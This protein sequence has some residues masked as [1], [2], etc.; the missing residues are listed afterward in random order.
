MP[1][2]PPPGDTPVD[3][4]KW[5]PPAG[6]AALDA[7][8]PQESPWAALWHGA[9][10]GVTD[11][12]H[13]LKQI[14]AHA[15]GRGPQADVAERQR[16]EAYQAS[17]GVRQHPVLSGAGRFAGNVV[18]GAPLALIPGGEG[19]WLGRAG[20]GAVSGA[21]GGASQPATGRDQNFAA[22]KLWQAA[23]GAG[24]GAG[25]SAAGSAIGGAV[26]P[27]LTPDATKLVEKGVTLTAGQMAPPYSVVRD[28][29][30][31]ATSYP[32][33]GKF[34]QDK[35]ARSIDSFNLATINQALEPIGAALPK[36]I[37]PAAGHDAIKAMSDAIGA[38]Y[39]SALGR[40]KS[41]D[42]ADPD[43]VNAFKAIELDARKRPAV[44][45]NVRGVMN[46]LIVNKL[47]RQRPMSGDELQKWTS[48]LGRQSRALGR[49]QDFFQ[50][51]E[52]RFLGD[53]RDALLDAVIRQHP[54][55]GADL[56]KA[57]E[58]WAMAVRIEDAAS[59]RVG[60]GGRFTPMDLLASTKSH[61]GGVR[62]REFARG[63]SLL[64]KWAE[65]GQRVLPSTLGESG[66]TPRAALLNPFA[67]AAGAALKPAFGFAGAPY[68]S[69]MPAAA[70]EL[71]EVPRQAARIA[72][73]AAG[74][75][76]GRATPRESVTSQ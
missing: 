58:A 49:S 57:N 16:E 59:R 9:L 62:R 39:K 10:Q 1:W 2:Q 6:D 31:R 53:A 50:R 38:A 12:Y 68:R 20:L 24:T 42:V 41:I 8:A 60:A 67:W 36:K 40:I 4:P 19:T 43:L 71:G 46:D 3:K 75:T 15:L 14:G 35:R 64:Q 63:D 54:Q 29:E 11:P 37:G 45:Q 52:G 28:I 47:K 72:A 7:Q 22:Q 26:A 65:T 21:L 25:V 5:T 34:L 44:W 13:G 51:E 74:A 48:D 18:G 69:Q 23:V 55:A 17:P 66:T 70:R 30:E 32:L 56:Q 76:T 33:I 61:A 73:P 27:R